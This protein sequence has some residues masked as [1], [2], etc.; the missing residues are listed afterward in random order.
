M[1]KTNTRLFVLF[2]LSLA[3]SVSLQAQITDLADF[4]S[5]SGRFSFSGLV[6]SQD[7][8]NLY[9]T[10][11]WGSP[12]GSGAVFSVPVSGGTPTVLASFNGANGARP[13]AGL[14]L[15]EDGTTL[16]GTTLY[17]GANGQGVVFS[18]PASGGEPTVLASFNGANGKELSAG[19]VLSGGV[20]YGTAFSGGS[21]NIG[22]VFSVPV[23]GGTPTVL[24]T[25]NGIN[26][27]S[28]IGRLVLNGDTLYGATEYASAGK[29]E[30]F[31][32]P[33]GGGVP[34]VLA[35]FNGANGG[36]PSTGL[37]LSGDTLYGATE[38][39]GTNGSGVVFSLPIAGGTPT[40]LASFNGTNGRWPAGL[41]LSQDDST[42]YGVTQEGGANGDGVIFSLPVA[43]G[44][45]TVLASFDGANGADPLG[46]LVLSGD[47]L[48]GATNVGGAN[49]F[50]VVFSVPASV[51]EPGI[52]GLLLTGTLAMIA[53]RRRGQV[54]A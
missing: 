54:I 46:E 3:G 15:S 28:P 33:I 48:Y 41:V 20:L 34:T 45:P 42:L 36:L 37:I 39:G 26:G 4:S 53:R 29:G 32:L 10:V 50:G 9:G 31:S 18:V 49:N 2:I 16:Y 23:S 12:S 17:G 51:P 5:D 27:Q 44:T 6:L 8:A 35:S 40:V 19:L 1:T 11:G 22:V 25:F 7:G 38:G 52:A 47:T 43:G 14:V 24:T 13:E 30:I 21:D